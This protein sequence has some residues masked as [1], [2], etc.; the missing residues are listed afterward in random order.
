MDC[1]RH[2]PAKLLAGGLH[3]SAAECSVIHGVLHNHFL[4]A[5]VDCDFVHT[6]ASQNG[7]KK[8][9]AKGTHKLLPTWPEARLEKILMKHVPFQI[10]PDFRSKTCPKI[11]VHAIVRFFAPRSSSF[12]AF[13]HFTVRPG[14]GKV[15]LASLQDDRHAPIFD[16]RDR[17]CDHLLSRKCV[18]WVRFAQGCRE[19]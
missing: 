6:D 8:S 3:L 4:G 17:F 10:A 15:I 11:T 13:P 1:E 5:P 16:L 14:R 2:I 12:T 18:D 7:P 19:T 9:S